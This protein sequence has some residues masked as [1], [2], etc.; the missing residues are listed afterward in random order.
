M[1]EPIAFISHFRIKESKLEEYKKRSKQVIEAWEYI[2]PTNRE[3][4]R[5]PN[6]QIL[7]MLKPAEDSGT[8][9]QF[10]PKYSDG[11]SRL[12]QVA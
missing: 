2:E 9:F 3:L 7:E 6:E 11:Y 12:N 1:S 10:K 5:I 8:V 4:Y